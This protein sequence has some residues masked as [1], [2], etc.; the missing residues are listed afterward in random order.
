METHNQNY[1]TK[2]YFYK[3]Q[4]RQN[5]VRN[6]NNGEGHGRRSKDDTRH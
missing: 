5:L 2:E 3:V 6:K 4:N 1:S